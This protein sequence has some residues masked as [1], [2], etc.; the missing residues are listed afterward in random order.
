MV[1]TPSRRQAL[2][3]TVQAFTDVGAGPALSRII[4]QAATAADEA[5]TWWS[6]R[7]DEYLAKFWPTEPFLA[8]AIY[9]VSTRNSSFRWEL[10]GTEENVWRYQSL[11]NEADF[12]GGW[13]SF[14]MKITNDLLVMGNGAFIEIIRPAKARTL[15]CTYKAIKSVHPETGEMGWFPY[16]DHAD[17]TLYDTAFKLVDSPKDLPVGI[18]HL[19]AH[20]CRRTGDPDYPVLYNDI[21][22]KLHKLAYYQV[23]TLEDMPSSRK[24]MHGVGYCLHGDS[25]VRMADGTTKMIRSIVNE[26]DPGP[27]IAIDENGKQVEKF[28]TEWYI[29]DIDGR[30]VVNIRGESS[31]YYRGPKQRNS[32]VT[33][34]HPVLTPKGWVSAGDLKTGDRIITEYPNPNELQLQL[35]IGS[36]LGDTHIQRPAR[37]T[38]LCMAHKVEHAKWIDIKAQALSEFGWTY[39]V[40]DSAYKAQGL[41]GSMYNANG[42]YLPSLNWL[43]EAFYSKNGKRKL[44]VELV[45]SNITPLMLVTWYLD[46]GNI[47]KKKLARG[48]TSYR[49]AIS[50]SSYKPASIREI[51]D[52]IT[53]AG[54]EC[55]PVQARGSKTKKNIYFTVNGSRN[56]FNDIAKYVPDC[57][58]YKLPPGL[59]EFDSM[60]WN[61]GD[62]TRFV[63][64]VIVSKPTDR[65]R[66]N[67]FR[68][69]YCIDVEEMH[70]FISAGVVVH[71]CSVD[72]CLRLAQILR[73][74]SIY[75]H[76]KVSGR[77]AR[78]IY[79]TNADA[80]QMEDAMTEA[81]A[82]A[83][84][85]GL[86]RYSQPVIF[87]TINPTTK[88]EVATIP[89]ASLPDAF[90]ED[91]TMR[92]YI[93]GVANAL[94]V[95][96][97]FLAPLPG[98]K[99]G[100]ADQAETQAEQAR[101]KSSRLF[102]ETLQNKFNYAGLFPRTVQF[103]FAYTDPGEESQ[104]DRGMALRA[105]IVSILIEKEVIPPPI[106]RQ[107]L[108]DWGDLDPKYLAML[109][110]IDLTPMITIGN[111]DVKIPAT[112]TSKLDINKLINPWPSS[113]SP[114]ALNTG[115]DGGTPG[116]VN[117][118]TS[119]ERDEFEEDEF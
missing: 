109:G 54:Y 53:E 113:S 17:K 70:N 34:D 45:K 20:R 60:A 8:G 77:F 33:T 14:I 55:N 3:K 119:P 50:C 69:V 11:L 46:D 39:R 88:P 64:K 111:S 93:A 96:Y 52:A 106:G 105:R 10:H 68:S 27:V 37:N 16:D 79:I 19:D 1:A 59:D 38:C 78:A 57:L 43:R 84:S 4:L 23:I 98:N 110:E 116:K 95:D 118:R 51:C 102:M 13:Q 92:W 85:K 63:D 61:L 9:A 80:Q 28:I 44:P 30:K 72:R 65:V 82:A 40:S 71:N 42:L 75:K 41:D 94:G 89:L 115:G 99:M 87:N 29:N 18:A 35:I 83:D 32:W 2:K 25:M 58:R 103:R 86:I 24:E 21:Q 12:G 108:A 101:G 114:E 31:R 104:R 62:A 36:A 26:K 100:T 112:F 91:E 90:S 48:G 97:G 7:R 49:A 107:L 66:G 5:P 15:K 22:G 74:M 56:L 6:H 76:E 67:K 47:L 117:A 81:T 73:D